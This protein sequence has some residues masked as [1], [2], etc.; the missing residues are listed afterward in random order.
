MKIID[1][2]EKDYKSAAIPPLKT[3]YDGIMSFYQ[4]KK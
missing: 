2:K 4:N 3:L 1:K